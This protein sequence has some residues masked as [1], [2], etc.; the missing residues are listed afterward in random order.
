LYTINLALSNAWS[1]TEGSNVVPLK[2]QFK[3]IPESAKE[4]KQTN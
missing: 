1:A 2:M 4:A 3:G